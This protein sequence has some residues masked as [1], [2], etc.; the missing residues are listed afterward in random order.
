MENNALWFLLQVGKLQA[1][2]Y[3][4]FSCQIKKKKK[5]SFMYCS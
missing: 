1:Q 2:Q 4:L 3:T 5:K